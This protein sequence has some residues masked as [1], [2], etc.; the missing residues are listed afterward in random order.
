MLKYDLI[1]QLLLIP[2][3]N[4]YPNMKISISFWTIIRI[5]IFKFG[6][7]PTSIQI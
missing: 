3:M 5:D 7:D 1:K 4:C 2:S 6:S